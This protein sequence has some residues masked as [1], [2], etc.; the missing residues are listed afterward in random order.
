MA[1]PASE[2]PVCCFDFRRRRQSAGLRKGI[3]FSRICS[4][5]IAGSR[6]PR[7]KDV[8]AL[9]SACMYVA[10]SLPAVSA[11][12]VV[13]AMSE[14]DSSA[15]HLSLPSLPFP[16]HPCPPRISSYAP[17]SPF[18]LAARLE[19][20]ARPS[21][22]REVHRQSR[23]HLPPARTPRVPPPGRQGGRGGERKRR[24]CRR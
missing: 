14:M 15:S 7:D 11:C 12:G 4:G 6:A 3:S 18:P 21:G 1:A 9:V 16:H 19:A 5:T 13:P 20:R 23:P 10:L 2:T 24:G 17:S 8:C 22:A